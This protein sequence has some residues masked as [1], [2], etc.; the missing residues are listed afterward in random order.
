MG[1]GRRKESI[2]Q[3]T[4]DCGVSAKHGDE[5]EGLDEIDLR[6]VVG[7]GG[8]AARVAQHHV[9]MYVGVEIDEA[10]A[11]ALH[12]GLEG[13]PVP[14]AAA[15]VAVIGRDGLIAF[16]FGPA[17][18]PVAVGVQPGERAVGTRDVHQPGVLEIVAAVRPFWYP[19]ASLV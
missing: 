5:T 12:E 7:G 11:Q 3:I 16:A 9:G 15:V 1:G 2:R 13:R 19:R 4:D 8:V 17:A 6:I 18:V 14:P 10:V